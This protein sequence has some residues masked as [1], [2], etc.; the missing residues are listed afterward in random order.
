MGPCF[1]T[2]SD[3]TLSSDKI[4][5]LNSQLLGSMKIINTG[6]RGHMWNGETCVQ[7]L[8]WVAGELRRKRR[9]LG[10]TD[11]RQN[12][13]LLLCDRCPSHMSSVF[14]EMRK[15]WAKENSVLLLGCDSDCP[16]QIPGGFGA[17]LGPNDRC[18]SGM[19]KKNRQ[20]PCFLQS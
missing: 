12:P 4:D 8:D 9:E 3:G 1:V 14:L 17:A 10:I 16:V 6:R 18:G 20:T 13:A 2:V 11:A 19:S 5:D 15:Q 7:F